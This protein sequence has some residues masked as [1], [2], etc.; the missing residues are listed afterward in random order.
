MGGRSAPF[1]LPLP[2]AGAPP[3]TMLLFAEAVF[4]LALLLLSNSGGRLIVGID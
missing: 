2:F 3:L 4:E 1:A